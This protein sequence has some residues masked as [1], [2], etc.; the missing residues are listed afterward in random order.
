MTPAPALARVPLG[1]FLRKGQVGTSL[2]AR[3]VR[4]R[5][6]PHT[7]EE[8]LARERSNPRRNVVIGP[9]KYRLEFCSLAGAY[10]GPA[11]SYS[12]ARGDDHLSLLG[13]LRMAG[14]FG[15]FRKSEGGL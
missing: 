3:T 8:N 15:R 14:I 7:G 9:V 12:R 4:S 1:L 10:R 6:S 13:C 11:V 5:R 2:S